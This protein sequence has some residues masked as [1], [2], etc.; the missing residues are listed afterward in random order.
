[1]KSQSDIRWLIDV[2]NEIVD[3]WNSRRE[4]GLAP[5]RRDINPGALR[6]HLSSISILE[7]DPSGGATFRLVGTQLRQLIGADM[8]GK[9]I[10]ELPDHFADI[11]RTGRDAFSAC[12]DPR[13]GIADLGDR[14]HAWLRLPLRAC[15]DDTAPALLLCH[16]IIRR[17]KP[18]E[19]RS[20]FSFHPTAGR[21][22][23]A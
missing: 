4:E 6:A 21:A 1:M 13:Q 23:A 22:V 14:H 11:W 3:Y 18:R 20:I 7:L 15:A 2:Q 8:R 5:S 17:K 9:R 16:D 10:D 19:Y 12:A